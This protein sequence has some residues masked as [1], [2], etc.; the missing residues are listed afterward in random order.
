MSDPYAIG[1][2]DPAAFKWLSGRPRDSK[3]RRRRMRGKARQLRQGTPPPGVT[4]GVAIRALK[5]VR[6]SC[7]WRSVPFLSVLYTD[8]G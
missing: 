7:L 2:P 6:V 8:V 1:S 5:M 4:S 3:R